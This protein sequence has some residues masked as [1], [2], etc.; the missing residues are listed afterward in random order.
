MNIKIRTNQ[1]IY[2]IEIHGEMEMSD[3]NQ[4]K[5]LVMKM[6]EKRVERFILDV[7]NVKSIDSTG[8]GALIYISST[9]K[10]MNLDLALANVRGPVKAV[11]ERTRLSGYFPIYD[12]LA[13]AIQ[14][15][16]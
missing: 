1:T 16:S 14:I 10:K 13:Q 12:D 15:L 5:E 2:I 7:G 11:M 9:L 6:V 8:I 3:S 4:L